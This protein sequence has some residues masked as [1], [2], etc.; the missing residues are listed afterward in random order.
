MVHAAR[1]P[2]LSKKMGTRQAS[3]RLALER[4]LTEQE[5]ESGVELPLPVEDVALV[6]RA[7][8]IGLAVEAMNNPGGV[9]P[10]LFPDFTEFVFSQLS[11]Q[12]TTVPR[13]E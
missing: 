3:L 12:A 11:E 5:H 9:R 8:G 6:M 13:S 1:D 7:L 2:E 4:Y 10:A